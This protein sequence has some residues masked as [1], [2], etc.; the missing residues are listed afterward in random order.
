MTA[1]IYAGVGKVL[2]E[3]LGSLVVDFGHLAKLAGFVFFDSEDGVSPVHLAHL[4][5]QANPGAELV[6]PLVGRDCNR[7]GL[8]AGA[9]TAEALGARALLL[10]AGHL[11]PLSPARSVYELDPIQ[12]LGFLQERGIRTECWVASKAETA[13]ERAR[14]QSLARAGAS[15]SLVLWPG[16]D[17]DCP[18]PPAAL[19]IPSLFS[20]P[21]RLWRLGDV[22]PGGDL[23]LH[24][25][26]G[27]GEAAALVAARLRAQA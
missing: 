4:A 9:R 15:R 18:S 17:P 1:R 23:V 20:V 12:M 22:P 27:G 24:V 6:L 8:L 10:L 21:E 3:E 16:V 26:P 13:A 11:D 7:T 5:R 14:I 2:P 25:S 19:P